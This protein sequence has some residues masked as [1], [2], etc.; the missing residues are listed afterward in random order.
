MA[1]VKSVADFRLQV[2]SYRYQR[3]QILAQILGQ[4]ELEVI[5]LA[6]D[7]YFSKIALSRGLHEK[8]P[9]K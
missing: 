9:E 7:D 4:P 2:S 6:I 8:V 5:K 3:I 1:Q